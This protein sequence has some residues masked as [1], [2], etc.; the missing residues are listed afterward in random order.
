MTKCR[1]PRNG[2]RYFALFSLYGSIW[3]HLEAIGSYME[4]IGSYM[5]AFG[6]WLF[7]FETVWKHLEVLLFSLI[8]V[9]SVKTVQ[10][11]ENSQ[12]P[13]AFIQRKQCKIA[14]TVSWSPALCHTNPL[15]PNTLQPREC[16]ICSLDAGRQMVVAARGQTISGK[17]WALKT[18]ISNPILH[19]GSLNLRSL[20]VN[21]QRLIFIARLVKLFPP[22]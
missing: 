15:N 16:Y 1:R 3:K 6:S 12:L 7:S 22:S 21:Q 5:E 19:R 17:H 20:I 9:F 14:K 11:S 10:N 4:A 2:Y 8:C 18:I 13:N